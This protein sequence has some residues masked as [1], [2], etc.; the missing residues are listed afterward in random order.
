MWQSGIAGF[1]VPRQT[2]STGGELHRPAQEAGSPEWRESCPGTPGV[3][4]SPLHRRPEIMPLTFKR[5][6]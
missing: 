2:P 6:H 5:I 4:T 1:K 3:N